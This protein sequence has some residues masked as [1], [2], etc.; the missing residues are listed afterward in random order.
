MRE[1]AAR[2]TVRQRSQWSQER[3]R[4]NREGGDLTTL[5][6]DACSQARFTTALYVSKPVT[7]VKALHYYKANA[8]VAFVEVMY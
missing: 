7:I 5:R 2:T 4:R 1:S 6:V 3:E 8:E